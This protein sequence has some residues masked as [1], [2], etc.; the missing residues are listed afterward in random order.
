MKKHQLDHVP[1]L[2][3]LLSSSQRSFSELSRNYYRVEF[4]VRVSRKAIKDQRTMFDV[5]GYDVRCTNRFVFVTALSR[6]VQV[7]HKSGPKGRKEISMGE[8]EERHVGFEGLQSELYSEYFI[9]FIFASLY[10]AS[11]R[12]VISYNRNYSLALVRNWLNSYHCK[13][14]CFLKT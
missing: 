1:Q 11:F 4:R 8:L 13:F 3:V 6:P 7:I 10:S 9:I 14:I 12:F 2:P 5:Q